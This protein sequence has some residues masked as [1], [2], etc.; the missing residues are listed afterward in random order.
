M[1]KFFLIPLTII[2]ITV[3]GLFAQDEVCN[4][5]AQ[6]KVGKGTL[7]FAWGYN[8]DWFSKSDIHFKNHTNELNPVTGNHDYYDFTL[9]DLNAR[10]RPGFKNVLT[11]PLT[12]PQYVYRIGYYFND[13]YNLG[14][15][16]NF[17]H[18]KYIVNDY[19]TAHLKGDIRGTEYDKDTLI[20]PQKFMHFQHTNGANFLMLNL[21]KRQ[22]LFVSH[23][24]KHWV[25]YVAKIGAGIVIPRTVVTLFGQGSDNFWHIAGYCAGIETGFRYDAF[26]H[27]YLEYTAKG[28]YANY[29][30]VLTIGSG[31]ANHH[32]WAFENILT[33]GF[34]F[35][36]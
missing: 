25:S 9:Y 30:D 33:A 19:Q 11:T 23:N 28:T 26:K 18:A 29:V 35:P 20:D 16:L 13:K 36:L 27:I 1:N 7:Y 31:R 4:C 12:I 5:P 14:I 17:D 24:K 3:N 2:L 6:S 22:T 10:D 8:K 32:F 34:Q 21:M 15:E